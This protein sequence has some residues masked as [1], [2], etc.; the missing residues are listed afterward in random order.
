MPDNG[1]RRRAA[2]YQAWSRAPTRTSAAAWLAA[3][4]PTS[5]PASVQAFMAEEPWTK[6]DSVT[7]ARLEEI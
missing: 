1:A 4:E 6:W 7:F 3:K 2:L 5:I